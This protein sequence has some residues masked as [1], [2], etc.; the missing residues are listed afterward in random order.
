[1]QGQPFFWQVDLLC[2]ELSIAVADNLGCVQVLSVVGILQDETDPMVSV[3][4]VRQCVR[5]C[6]YQAYTCC[7]HAGHAWCALVMGVYGCLRKYMWSALLS[8]EGHSALKVCCCVAQR[9]G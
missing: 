9:A 1:M 5:V 6:F 2:L 8:T 4:K 3:M 7:T